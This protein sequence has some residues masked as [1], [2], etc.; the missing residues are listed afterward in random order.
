MFRDGPFARCLALS[1]PSLLNYD[2]T[3]TLSNKEVQFNKKRETVLF[4]FNIFNIY[5]L[6]Q[7]VII[8]LKNK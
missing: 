6:V 7:S 3:I 8:K 1:N 4:N 2:T 5:I